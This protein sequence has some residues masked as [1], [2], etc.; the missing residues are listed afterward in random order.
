MSSDLRAELPF[1]VIYGGSIALVFLVGTMLT[2]FKFL[3]SQA[4]CFPF[5]NALKHLFKLQQGTTELKFRC[6]LTGPYVT[7]KKRVTPTA[8]GNKLIVFRW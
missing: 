2:V 1:A 4:K 8:N 3:R 5:L 7:A 6:L